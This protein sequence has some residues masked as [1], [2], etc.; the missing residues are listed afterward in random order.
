MKMK[1]FDSLRPNYFIFMGYLKTGVGGESRVQANA[2]LLWTRHWNRPVFSAAARSK[3]LILLSF[4]HCFVTHIVCGRGGGRD[5]SVLC[6]NK[7]SSPW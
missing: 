6:S 7:Q 5:G 1:Y 3:A 2:N 4:M